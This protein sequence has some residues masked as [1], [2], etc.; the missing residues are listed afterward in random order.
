MLRNDSI[1]TTIKQRL[2]D[3]STSDFTGAIKDIQRGIER[4]TL[5]VAPNGKISQK[6]HPKLLGAALTHPYITTD[7]SEA[8]LE[9]ITPPSNDIN[10]TYAQLQDIHHFVTKHIG[11]EV[12]WPMSMPCFIEHQDEIP[13]AYYGES[14]IGKMKRTYRKGL[15][16]RYGSM[17]Q[18]IAGIHYNF[19]LPTTFWQAYQKQQGLTGSLMDFQSEQ[20]MRM[21]RNIKRYVWVVTYLFGASPAMCRS[22]LEGKGG[23]LPFETFGKGSV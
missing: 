10:K 20:Y 12:L 17:M 15:K 9:L 22:F 3:L 11:D 13:L 23:A 8:L 2:D 1:L 5:R 7:Y 19:S 6:E 21:V 18:A 16:N 4:E 14:N